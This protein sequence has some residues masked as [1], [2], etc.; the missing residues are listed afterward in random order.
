MKKNKQDLVERHI[1]LED[2]LKDNYP[3][4]ITDNEI[5]SYFMNNF[6]NK[7][8]ILYLIEAYFLP[9]EDIEEYKE[10]KFI[11]DIDVYRDLSIKYSVPVDCIIKRMNDIKL[12]N[13]ESI[14]IY[15]TEIDNIKKLDEEF[16]CFDGNSI[17][18]YIEIELLVEKL[19][20]SGL[21]KKLKNIILVK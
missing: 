19:S 7:H 17:F 2:W 6:T 12:M 3:D 4:N 21:S 20:I 16:D 8:D 13:A 11:G 1:Y 18:K 10:N 15:S 5:L 9:K 14:G